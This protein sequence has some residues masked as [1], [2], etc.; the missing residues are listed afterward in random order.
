MVP[1]R[2]DVL[3][4][5]RSDLE[6]NDAKCRR[7]ET[8][9]LEIRIKSEIWIISSLYKQPSVKSSILNEALDEHIH[10]CEVPM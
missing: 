10:P 6:M 2:D 3:H 9:V 7:I 1:I 4:K 5:R 8:L